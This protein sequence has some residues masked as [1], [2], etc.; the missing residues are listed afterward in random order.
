MFTKIFKWRNVFAIATC[1][2][3]TATFSSCEEASL[4]GDKAI[5]AFA[6]IVPPAAGVVDETAKTI[7]VAVP[8]DTDVTALEPVIVLS[9]LQATVSP[10][11]GV[12]QNFTNPVVY[13]VTAEDGST[14]AYTV[15]V[16]VGGTPGPGPEPGTG[17]GTQADPFI[18]ATTGNRYTGAITTQKQAIWYAFT[19]N[20]RYNLTVGDRYYTPEQGTSS[21][22]VDARVSVLDANLSYVGDINN[23]Q[24]NRQDIGGNSNAVVTLTDL[25][26]L[27]YVKIEPYSAGNEGTFFISVATTGPITAGANQETAIDITTY[28]PVAFESELTSSR[29]ARWF[30]FTANGRYDLTVGDRYYTPEHGTSSYT[31]DAR[32]T[33]LNANLGY[34]SDIKNRQ[35]NAV[36]IGSNSNAVVT[37]TDLSGVYYVKVEPYSA[38]NFG[39]FF[40]DVENTGPI[41]AGA[42]QDDAIPLTIGAA[43]VMDELTSSRPA[44][45]FKF[46][47]PQGGRVELTVYDRY[48][49]PSG[50]TEEKPTLDVRVTVLNANLSYVSDASNR[51][52]NGIDIGN[53]DQS[54]VV[55]TNLTPGAVYYVK[56]DPYSANNFGSFY[57]GVN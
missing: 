22:T 40:I 11:T 23:R 9:S 48:Y 51:Q 21:Y 2:A 47:A 18:L 5:T 43:R 31:V 26:G 53:N 56:I 15:T 37:L 19:A 54:P 35:M 13:T 17:S 49:E 27:Y 1:L 14:A 33:V 20:G 29:P 12:A 44:R 3:V 24:M 55:F 7:T 34:V 32:V 6:F 39:S 16:T 41:T 4:S 50:M 46:T 28:N 52:M 30:K 38:N 8:V 36:D 57:I 25:S 10:A 42:G 45:W